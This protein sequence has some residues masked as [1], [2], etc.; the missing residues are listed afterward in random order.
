[1]T[2]CTWE[3]RGSHPTLRV[4][5]EASK[6]GY[7]RSF[8]LAR[9]SARY[10]GFQIRL[11]RSSSRSNSAAVSATRLFAYFVVTGSAVFSVQVWHYVSSDIPLGQGIAG[12]FAIK[13]SRYFSIFDFK[14]RARL[15]IGSETTQTWHHLGRAKSVRIFF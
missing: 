3:R 14:E 10:S 7:P 12:P 11:S 13:A 4:A 1:M 9:I 8:S 6:D 2:E 5:R 15:T